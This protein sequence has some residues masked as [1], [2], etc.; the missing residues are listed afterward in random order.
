[1]LIVFIIMFCALS[2]L[3]AGVC[4]GRAGEGVEWTAVGAEGAAGEGQ[5]G[6]GGDTDAVPA[7]Q[8]DQREGEQ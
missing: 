3:T 2:T 8:R 5:S 1:M 6:A 7:A 4:A